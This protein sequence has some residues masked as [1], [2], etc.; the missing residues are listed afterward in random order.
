MVIDGFSTDLKSINAGV[1]QGSVLP[2]TLFLICINDLLSLTANPIYS[3]ADDS[4][5]CHSY[6]FS[7]RPSTSA[8]A[9]CRG[10]MNDT[11][12]NDLNKI[13]KWG[14]LNRVDFNANKTQSCLL[15]HKRVDGLDFRTRIAGVDVPQSD[16]LDMLGMQIQSNLHWDKHIFGIAKKAAQSIG[17]LKRCKK[18]FT[19]LDL[20]NIYTSY[21]RPKMEYNSHIWA[22]APRASLH[23]LDSVQKRAKRLIGDDEVFSSLSLPWAIEGTWDA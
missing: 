9:E 16:G 15:T 22:E 17:L 13:L 6:S 1:P 12:N 18:Y 19:P 2:P 7:R 14:K 21:I 3:F 11:L 4:S 8:V 23:Y 20:R 5:L 10:N